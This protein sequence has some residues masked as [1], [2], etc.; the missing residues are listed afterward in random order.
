MCARIRLR[1]LRPEGPAGGVG[2]GVGGGVGG[3]G[4]N[5][6]V[7]HDSGGKLLL[8]LLETSTGST[9]E[10]VHLERERERGKAEAISETAVS[11]ATPTDGLPF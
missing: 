8:S 7:R 5:G 2:R 10:R 9:I 3:G 11:P 6:F 1:L 4:L